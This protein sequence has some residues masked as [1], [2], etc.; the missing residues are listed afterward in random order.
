MTN[1]AGW[2]G[3]EAIKL[4]RLHGNA[5][6]QTRLWLNHLKLLTARGFLDRPIAPN[7]IIILN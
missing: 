2:I 7:Y 6:L 3:M 1:F 4:L 5:R